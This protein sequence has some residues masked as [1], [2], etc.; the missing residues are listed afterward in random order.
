MV[1]ETIKL[2]DVGAA[3]LIRPPAPSSPRRTE[4]TS[5]G[6]GDR[7]LPR[8]LGKVEGKRRPEVIAWSAG[9]STLIAQTKKNS[10]T[11]CFALCSSGSISRSISSTEKRADWVETLI[12]A[13]VRPV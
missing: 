5:S 10:S 13:T 2:A 7:P 9:S 8:F 4:G 6:V 3:A 11:R 12:A 1:W